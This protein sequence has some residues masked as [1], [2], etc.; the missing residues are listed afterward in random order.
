[1]RLYPTSNINLYNVK[2]KLSNC[3]LKELNNKIM[4]TNNGMYKYYKNEL[5]LYKFNFKEKTKILDNYFKNY[6]LI[7]TPDKWIKIDKSYNLP[8][9]H[10][11]LDVTTLTFTLRKNAPVKFVCEYINN[12]IND[13]FFIIPENFEM[14]PH[15]K[16]D[17]CSFLNKL[18]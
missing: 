3:I 7:L 11:I 12:E 8:I 9:T 16:E 5:Y 17:I 14:D 2:S 4:L 10:E 13:Y 18:D 15:I 1:M 6:N